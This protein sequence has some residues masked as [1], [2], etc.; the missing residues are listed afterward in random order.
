MKEPLIQFQNVFKK[1]GDQPVLQGTDL[2][3]FQGEVA[4]IIGKSG[5]GKSVLLKHIIGLIEPDSG[6]ILFRGK[7]L[8]EMNNRAKRKLKHKLSYMFQ[9]T[10]LFDSLDIFDNIA[11]PLRERGS[12][13]EQEVHRRVKEKMK[14]LDLGG[15]DHKFPSE[16]SGGMKKRVALARALVTD[17]EIILF[18]EPTTGL[19]PIRKAT[20]HHMIS[21]YQQKFGFTGVMVS[22][23]IPDIFYIS[24][25]V[26]M[27]NEGRIVF[28]GTPEEIRN[29]SDPVVR[30][31]IRGLD[32]PRDGLTGMPTQL[33][34]EKKFREE[35]AR[36]LRYKI[37]FSLV[38]FKLENLDEIS[39]EMGH[40]AAQTVLINFA[41][42]VKNRIRIFDACSRAG[43]DKIMVILPNTNL[44][45]ARMFCAKLANQL[46]GNEI[47]E[48]QPYP[49]FCFTVTAGYEEIKKEETIDDVLTSTESI[50]NSFFEF[51]VC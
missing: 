6:K 19:D 51:I 3:I 10:A 39:R 31:F 20:V 1:F 17:P 34:V 46:K 28:E 18:D 5:A 38:L 23:E 4:T 36:M 47:L 50:K 40:L 22:H 13:S 33:Q 27:L 49:G 41:T 48:V 35:V 12:F 29:T 32:T 25:R 7:P 14:Q 9:S 42:Q 37:S 21:E 24:Q 8:S 43:Q 30:N 45:Q 15:I 26:A 44:K 16:I 11:L 2:S